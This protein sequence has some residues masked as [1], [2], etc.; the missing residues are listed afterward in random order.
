MAR[1]DDEADYVVR[2]RALEVSDIPMVDLAPFLTGTAED[3]RRVAAEIAAA[4]QEIGFFY[5]KNHGVPADALATLR[6]Q[7]AAFFA[8]PVEERARSAATSDWYRGWMDLSKVGLSSRSRQIESFRIQTEHPRSTSP[9]PRQRHLYAPNR[10]PD[11]MP[12]FRAAADRYFALMNQ[13]SASLRQ[14]FALGLG[15]P[16]DRFDR[17]YANPIY[18]LTLLHY[19][20]IPPEDAA[21]VNT[22]PHT[23][24]GPFTILW[25]D[26]VGGLEVKRRDGEWIAAPPIPDTF[27]VN[28]GDMLMWWS[29]GRYLSN[30]HKVRNTSGRERYSIPF[31]ANP[32]AEADIA[33]LPE[34][35]AVDGEARYPTM[36]V[37]DCMMKFAPKEIQVP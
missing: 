15:L 21:A 36:N 28:V 2:A 18:Q 4:C 22:T 8:R 14:A 31:F 6:Q 32:D 24:D 26:E 16:E 11:D 30:L 33:P 1:S 7:S 5:I 10:W 25:Q 17:Y 19:G 9:D 13:L 27:V 23:D 12:M 37:G 34:F 29:N 3:R 20:A 35:V